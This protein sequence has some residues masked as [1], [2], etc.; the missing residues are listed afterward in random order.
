MKNESTSQ[1]PSGALALCCAI[2]VFLAA[3]FDAE[4][5]SPPAAAPIVHVVR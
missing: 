3:L 1:R 5:D 2:A 4:T